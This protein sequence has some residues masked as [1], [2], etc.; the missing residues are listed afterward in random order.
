MDAR[1]MRIAPYDMIPFAA[2]RLLAG[3]AGG[4]N[5]LNP[6]AKCDG[7]FHSQ[8]GGVDAYP[9]G[10]PKGDGA[11]MMESIAGKDESFSHHRY[12]TVP[13]LS[14]SENL[15]TAHLVSSGE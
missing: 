2:V 3:K 15:M 14:S 7:S 1:E 5:P 9:G 11:S 10:F 12:S 6:G 4:P 13:T 8:R